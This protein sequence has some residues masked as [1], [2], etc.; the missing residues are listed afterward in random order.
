MLNNN[1]RP[2]IQEHDE[3]VFTILKRVAV[4]RD[5]ATQTIHLI[6][7]RKALQFFELTPQHL[8]VLKRQ[9]I[10][11]LR[12]DEP[13]DAAIDAI[14][15]IPPQTQPLSLESD[16]KVLITALMQAG[17][18][19]DLK[20]KQAQVVRRARR[21]ALYSKLA[22]AVAS[23]PGQAGELSSR[24]AADLSAQL[25][26]PDHKGAARILVHGKEAWGS[27][28][29]MLAVAKALV[30]EGYVLRE[31]DAASL[32]TEGE[33]G[34]WVGYD[35]IW[36]GATYGKITHDVHTCRRVVWVIRNLDL[37]HPTV[38]AALLRRDREIIERLTQL[39]PPDFPFELAADFYYPTASLKAEWKGKK[40][41]EAYTHSSPNS[42]FEFE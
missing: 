5:A 3:G 29:V 21:Q 6:D 37:C 31:I 26:Q 4:E 7:V 35:P 17:D 25:T 38:Q 28:A 34:A 40:V 23:V 9:K 32:R 2:E 8:S 20:F 24:L 39:P 36:S 19:A 41:T 30:T 15:R 10:T 33:G 18:L 27:N 42:H 13:S 12:L 22:L 11:R 14:F 16:V 1:T